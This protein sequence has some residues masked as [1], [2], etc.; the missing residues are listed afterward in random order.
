MA[1]QYS[2]LWLGSAVNWTPKNIFRGHYSYTRSLSPSN[3]DKMIVFSF[4]VTH[5]EAREGRGG[6]QREKS[7]LVCKVR[8]YECLVKVKKKFVNKKCKIRNIKQQAFHNV[9]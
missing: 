1:D 5:K 4:I 6:F 7:P 3:V 8:N 2:Y 9:L